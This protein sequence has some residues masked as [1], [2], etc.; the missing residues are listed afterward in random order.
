MIVTGSAVVEWVAKRTNEFGNFGCATGIGWGV[1]KT[2]NA[3]GSSGYD[4]ADYLSKN[5]LVAGVAYAEWNGVNV[6]CHIASDGTKRWLTREFLWTIFDYPFNQLGCK[7][8]TV[9]VGS[10]NAASRKFVVHLGFS[11]EATLFG[12]HPT[13]DILIYRMTRKECRWISAVSS[14]PL[15]KAA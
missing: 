13:G 9:C 7:R 2:L 10:G 14:K 11:E 15:A 1:A 3:R 8:I 5:N 4:F 6:V 12:A